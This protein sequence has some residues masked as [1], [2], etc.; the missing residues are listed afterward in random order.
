MIPDRAQVAIIGG[1]GRMGGWLADLLERSGHSVLKVGRRTKVAP[2][3][4]ARSC[5][6]LA[7]SVP[8]DKTI[9]M[10][11]RIGPLIRK[12]AL[13]MDLTSI[14]LAPMK[15]MLHHSRSQVV[16]LHPLF[17]PNAIAGEGP[18]TV[19]VC[20]GRGET[21]RCWI[22]DRLQGE[23]YCVR[24]IDPAEHDRIMGVVQGANHFATLAFALFLR[25]SGLPLDVFET[26]STPAFRPVL[27]RIH[28]LLSQPED[29][30]KGLLRGNSTVLPF[31]AQYRQAVEDIE[32]TLGGQ[33]HQ[34][35]QDVLNQ[36][37]KRFGDRD[38][39]RRKS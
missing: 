14:K 35:F 1:T 11:E 17:G 18:L 12:N 23:G 10:I 28:A 25:R 39:A 22:R 32:E 6:V 20:P 3:E 26:W 8:L 34:G 27:A 7:I 5:D 31:V 30:V 24:E 37:G 4:A 16:G 13:L 21:G 15:A 36:I 19:A 9:P 38:M 2:E 29:L 33:S